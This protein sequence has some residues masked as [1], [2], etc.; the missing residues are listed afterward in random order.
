[1]TLVNSTPD[2]STDMF[3]LICVCQRQL[4]GRSEPVD[5]LTEKQK[6]A[7]GNQAALAPEADGDSILVA[8]QRLYTEATPKKTF[9][10]HTVFSSERWL[11][12]IGTKV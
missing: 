8:M 3:A 12:S 7:L 10:E 5:S 6:Q 11:R 2:R 4:L 9:P 1:M